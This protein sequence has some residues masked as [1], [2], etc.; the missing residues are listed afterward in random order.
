MFLTCVGNISY[1]KELVQ[2]QEVTFF[3]NHTFQKQTELSQFEIVGPN[4]RLKLSLPLIKATR[5]GPYDAV[6]LDYHSN[7]QVEHWR[8]I[9]NAYKKAPFFLYYGYKIQPVFQKRHE[10]LVDFNKAMLEAILNCIKHDSDILFSEESVA[11]SATKLSSTVAYPQ[12]FDAK[13]NFE[14]NLSILD[15]IFNLGPETLDYLM[16]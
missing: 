2:N 11:Y 8:S 6:H 5:K 16:H 3:L 7:W 9:E 1:W 14:S 15:V 4:G 12:V 10:T 13:L